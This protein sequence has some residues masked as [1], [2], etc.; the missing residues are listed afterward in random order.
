[1]KSFA[2]YESFRDYIATET[3]DGENKY[4]AGEHALQV[5]IQE[6]LP[7]PSYVCQSVRARN[8]YQNVQHYLLNELSESHVGSIPGFVSVVG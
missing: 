2:V 7:T 3:M 6:S 8:K 1:M 4:D 5:R